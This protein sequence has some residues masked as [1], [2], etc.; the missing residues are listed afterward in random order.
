M[1][2]AGAYDRAAGV[3]ALKRCFA[4]S[5]DGLRMTDDITLETAQAV[6]WVFLL[7]SR[8]AW[9]DGVLTAG[10]IAVQCP[11]GLDFSAEDIP[12][13]DGRMARNWK[14]SLWRVLLRS[15]AAKDFRAE[16]VFEAKH[17]EDGR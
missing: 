10:K 11:A 9:A 2:L 13:T 3:T 1:D 6:T 17:K 4:L 15:E 5:E 8:P 7:R 14:G 16:F 12:V